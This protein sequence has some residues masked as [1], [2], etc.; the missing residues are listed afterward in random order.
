MAYRW[1]LRMILFLLVPGIVLGQNST[2]APNL[3]LLIER[4]SLTLYVAAA[5]PLALDE[6]S[7]RAVNSFGEFQSFKLAEG[8]KVL[9]LTDGLAEPGSCFIYEMKDAAAPLPSICSKPN[10]VF[11]L[12]VPSADVFWYD[13]TANQKRDLA[14]VANDAVIALC[15]AAIPDCPISYVLPDVSLVTQSAASTSTAETAGATTTARAATRIPLPTSEPMVT[16]EFFMPVEH[17]LD[18][19][20]SGQAFDGVEMVLVPPGCFTMGSEDGEAD[21]Q[22]M[23]QQ[24]FDEFY[25]ID[26]YEVTNAQYRRCVEADIC[27]VPLDATQYNDPEYADY[28]VNVNWF[29]ARDYAAWRGGRL[30]TEAQWE[31]AARGPDGLLYPWGNEFDSTALNFCDENCPPSG[32]YERDPSADDGYAQLAPVGTFPGGV[33]WVGAQDM[34]GNAWEWTSTIYQPYPYTFEDGRE[35]QSMA[36]AFRVLRGGTWFSNA[37]Q[38]RATCRF[39]TDPDVSAVARGLRVVHAY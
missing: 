39:Q 33:S 18:W 31:Y 36:D 25:W 32:T 30:P 1:L 29:Q 14:I 8:F 11:R 6:L 21:E 12:I 28:P 4:E 22:P 9:K 20:P 27:I 2:A 10:L 37:E 13:L 19:S 26:R 5:D 23:T 38:A 16:P 15:S 34:A 17:N 24:C 7:F 3:H 35:D